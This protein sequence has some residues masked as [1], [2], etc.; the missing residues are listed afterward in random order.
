MGTELPFV[1]MLIVARNEGDYIGKCLESLLRQDYP[2]NLYEI[3]IVDGMS[4]DNTVEIA[5][6][7][8]ALYRENKLDNLRFQEIDVSFYENPK[9][10]LASGWN[11]GIKKAKGNYVV[12]IDAHA[13]ALDDFLSESVNT[14]LEVEDATC[15]GGVISTR[16]LSKIGSMITNVLSSPFGVGNSRFRYSDKP[17]YVDT[18]AYGLYKK[19]IFEKIGYF[20]ETMQ[21]AQ[22]N[23]MHSRIKNAGGKFYLNPSIK[24]IYYSRDSV[25][26]MII[27][28]FMNGKWIIINL[29]RIKGG[30]PVR[31]FVPLAFILGLLTGIFLSFVHKIFPLLTLLVLIVYFLLSIFFSLKKTKNLKEIIIMPWLFLLW[32]IS[33]GLGSFVGIIFNR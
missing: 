12:R 22:D 13:C 10:N 26:K 21:R 18:V 23:E 14:I 11:I 30:M 27:Q 29:K 31:Y 8:L 25:K 7:L 15:V 4:T 19:D 1:S 24:T 2:K 6:E 16:S 17:G 32:H 3:I 5:K 9:I 20:D 28:A 33:Y